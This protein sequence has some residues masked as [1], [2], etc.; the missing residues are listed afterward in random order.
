MGDD[1]KADNVKD[2]LKRDLEQTKADLP[3]L[4][5]DDIDQDAGDTVRQAL[6]K[7]DEQA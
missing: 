4:K 2:A 5:G 7:D 3:G 1:S 6:G